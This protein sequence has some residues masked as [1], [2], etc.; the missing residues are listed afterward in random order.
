VINPIDVTHYWLIP[1]AIIPAILGTILIF[2]DQQITSVIV[3]RKEH[4]LQA[5]Q[6]LAISSLI[7]AIIISFSFCLFDVSRLLLCG[8]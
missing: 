7:L 4:K 3:N 2:L 8:K 6:S 1:F 5:N